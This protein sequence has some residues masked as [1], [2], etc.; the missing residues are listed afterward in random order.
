MPSMLVVRQLKNPDGTPAPAHVLKDNSAWRASHREDIIEPE[1]PIIDAHHHLWDKPG[2][3]Y[4]IKEFLA[5]IQSG[6]N[7]QGTVYIEGGSYY[8]KTVPDM[9][10]HLGEVEFAN[11][12]AAVAASQAYGQTLVAA[13]IVGGADLTYG[14]EIAELLD[15]QIATA[16]RRYR[17]IRLITKW[18]ADEKLNNGRYVIEPGLLAHPTFRAGF[19]MLGPRNLSFD[20]MVYHHQLLELAELARAFPDTTINLNHIGGFVGKTR[21]YV[22]REP[23]ALAHWQQSMRELA[24]CPNVFVKLGGLGMPYLGFGME[25]LERPADSQRLAEV[26]GPYFKFCIETFGA[27]RCMFESNFPPDRE[28]V[29]YHVLWNAFKRI[30]MPYSADEKHALFFGTAAR[31]YRLEL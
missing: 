8:G 7:I 26:W 12:M 13:G 27:E 1:R 11:G 15:A 22:E 31:A 3:T 28:S 30:A 10:K 17:G 4:L 23:E 21:T 18:D 19:A 29:E 6:H 20:A 14:A 2:Q 9:M 25:A 24:K 16:S 5:D